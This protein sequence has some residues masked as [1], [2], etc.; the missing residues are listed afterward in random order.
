MTEKLLK[1]ESKMSRTEAAEKLH[2]IADKVGEGKIELS[3]GNDSVSLTPA[4]NVEFQIEVE[5]EKDGDLSIE[6]EIEWNDQETNE[7][8]EIN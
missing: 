2:E 4:D 1:T 5:E 8:V 6:V 3:S 7:K